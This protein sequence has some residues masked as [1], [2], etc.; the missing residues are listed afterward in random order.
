MNV[1]I[2]QCINNTK[3]SLCCPRMTSRNEYW[4]FI[5]ILRWTNITWYELFG[6][7]TPGWGTAEM[8]SSDILAAYRN[9]TSVWWNYY[10]ERK[11]SINWF[12]TDMAMNVHHILAW[13]RHQMETFSALLAIC[14]GNS[15]VTGEFPAQRPVTQSFDVFFDLRLNKRFSKQSLGW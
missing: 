2:Y 15:S 14:A 5:R 9:V 7:L 3:S 12:Y 1:I 6:L 8:G 10:L 11:L 4:Y 13:W